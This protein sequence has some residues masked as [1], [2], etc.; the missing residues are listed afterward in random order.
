M[1]F[2]VTNVP[3]CIGSNAKTLKLKHQQ[4]PDTGVSSSPPDMGHVVCVC[5]TERSNATIIF[6]TGD[7]R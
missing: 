3:R 6:Y 4:F 5:V 1:N 2:L 7:K